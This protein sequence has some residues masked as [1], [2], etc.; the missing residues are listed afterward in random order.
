MDKKECFVLCISNITKE[1][2]LL[3]PLLFIFQTKY[4]T[5]LFLWLKQC[6]RYKISV[7]NSHNFMHQ[8]LKYVHPSPSYDFS[9]SLHTCQIKNPPEVREKLRELRYVRRTY[10]AL[11]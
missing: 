8:S 11:T 7:K 5:L 10:A 1:A 6:I 4:F 2:R 9:C 3:R